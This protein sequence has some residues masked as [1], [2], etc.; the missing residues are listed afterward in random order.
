MGRSR[1]WL[2]ASG[3]TAMAQRSRRGAGIRHPAVA[4]AT[5]IGIAGPRAVSHGRNRR[6]LPR[7]ERARMPSQKTFR[8]KR[9]LVRGP[10]R[11]RR[12]LACDLKHQA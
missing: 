10:A 12:R 9:M 6:T 2:P 3:H 8:Y 5:P 1:R 7:R 4:R 11:R